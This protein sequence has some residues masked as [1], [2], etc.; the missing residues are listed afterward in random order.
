VEVDIGELAQ[1]IQAEYPFDTQNSQRRADANLQVWYSPVDQRE[2]PQ[3]VA[4][5]AVIVQMTHRRENGTSPRTDSGDEVAGIEHERQ[6]EDA[7]NLYWDNHPSPWV[8]QGLDD[9]IV[10]IFSQLALP[11]GPSSFT[12][13]RLIPFCV[14][15][16]AAVGKEEIV[17][18]SSLLRAGY[19]AEHL[20]LDAPARFG[21]GDDDA[22]AARRV[23]PRIGQAHKYPLC[24]V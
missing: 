24:G 21:M 5:G 7:T 4:I 17:L 23:L 9:D 15:A 6:L 13:E 10:P 1:E 16:D 11:A 12:S 20:R 2:I 8:N 3:H 19:G 22:M 14:R 18:R